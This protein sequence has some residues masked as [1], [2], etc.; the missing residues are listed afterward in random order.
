VADENQIQEQT[1]PENTPVETQQTEQPTEQQ[2]AEGQTQPESGEQQA[3][4]PEKPARIHSTI[5]ARMDQLTKARRE[6]E[7]EA[8]ALKI[9]LERY[10]TGNQSKPADGATETPERTTERQPP[11]DVV[12]QQ[13]A[14]QLYRQRLYQERVNSTLSAGNK[15]YPDFTERCNVVAS[16]GAGDNPTFME[17]VTDP[18]IVPD[19]HKV[20]A[21]LADD[22][23]EAAR[24]LA[25]PPVAMSAEL[26]RY[27]ARVDTP[28]KPN[29]KAAPA[30]SKAPPPIK[31]L[32]G[33]AKASDEP[34]SD[35]SDDEWFRKRAAQRQQ[36][37]GRSL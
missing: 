29:G 28:A 20:I 33:S 34:S 7:R 24:I 3:T 22:P 14:E 36:R 26:A 30:V 23:N 2:V 31:P 35:D 37:R 32:T 21:S 19:G 17:I 1:A 10:K 25:L 6:A 11:D 9:E 27:A 18:M 8:A 13:R 5:Q 15:D 12:I 4:A 16:L